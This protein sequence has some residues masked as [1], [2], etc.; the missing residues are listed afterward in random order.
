MHKTKATGSQD[1]IPYVMCT[2]KSSRYATTY[3]NSINKV[4]RKIAFFSSIYFTVLWDTTQPS[5]TVAS[6]HYSSSFPTPF[7]VRQLPVQRHLRK[8]KPPWMYSFRMNM[9]D[10]PSFFLF[11]SSIYAEVYVGRVIK[12]SDPVNTLVINWYNKQIL[13]CPVTF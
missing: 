4:D 2:K 13:L 12:Q 3:Q 1:M 6:K 7:E 5:I 9:H 8:N 11:P 10:G